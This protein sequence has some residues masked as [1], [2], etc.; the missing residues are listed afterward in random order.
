MPKKNPPIQSVMHI[1]L[2]S[3][4]TSV[5]AALKP[6]LRHQPLIVQNLSGEYRIV[7]S[8]NYQARRLG[9]Q[10]NMLLEKAITIAPQVTVV[11]ASYTEY[12]NFS[13][14]FFNILSRFCDSIEPIALDEAYLDL[15]KLTNAWLSYEMLAA[16]IQKA[17]YNELEITCSIGIASNKVCAYAASQSK[18]PKAIVSIPYGQ[19]KRFL[20]QLPLSLLPGLGRRTTTALKK[21]NIH[22]IGQLAQLPEKVLINAFGN[23]GRSI[24]RL[25]NGQ[26]MRHV[27]THKKAE[28]ITRSKSFSYATADY[29]HVKSTADHLF[30]LA[31]RTMKHRQISCRTLYLRFTLENKTTISKQATFL[32][33][34]QTELQLYP[35]LQRVFSELPI[36]GLR[37]KTVHVGVSN[38][39]KLKPTTRPFDSSFNKVKSIKN[40]MNVLQNRFGFMPA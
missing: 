10:K 4:F 8:A 3:F 31:C 12:K 15:S 24:W 7:A 34:S 35:V 32:Y 16:T 28:S 6:Q 20:H 21:T 40:S 14:E 37:I 18:K 38:F 22:T 29:D 27:I 39:K 1:S 2:D 36:A 17:I 9:I 26:D 5:E 11:N 13:K 23:P 19:E 25:A 33:P 30:A